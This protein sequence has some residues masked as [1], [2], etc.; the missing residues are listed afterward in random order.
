MGEE[1]RAP[2]LEP[3]AVWLT[4]LLSR[5]L[6][7]SCFLA[8]YGSERTP[9]S[10]NAVFALPCYRVRRVEETGT[11]RSLVLPR[12]PWRRHRRRRERHASQWL[13][14]RWTGQLQLTEEVERDRYLHIG[15]SAPARIVTKKRVL[16]VWSQILHRHP[17]LSATV[18]FRDYTDIRFQCVLFF[19]IDPSALL[20][21]ARHLSKGAGSS[22]GQSGAPSARPRALPVRKR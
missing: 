8:I 10:Q 5:S 6:C 15:F 12:I 2:L 17:L 9:G 22:R 19:T 20:T 21:D 11:D 3:S 16:D 14:R 18:E 13:V 7:A 1:N 4:S